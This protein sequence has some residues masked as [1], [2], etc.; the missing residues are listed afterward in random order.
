MFSEKSVRVLAWRTTKT[1]LIPVYAKMILLAFQI[2]VEA[3][4]LNGCYV[5]PTTPGLVLTSSYLLSL[6]LVRVHCTSCP[7]TFTFLVVR[8]HSR[9]CLSK[10]SRFLVCIHVHCSWFMY[11]VPLIYPRWMSALAGPC[12]WSKEYDWLA[13]LIQLC[14]IAFWWFWLIL[15]HVCSY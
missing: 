13:N 9:P 2:F 3:W 8:T 11:T 15:W 4:R 5:S 10:L 7:S 14:N 12:C 1:T 6:L